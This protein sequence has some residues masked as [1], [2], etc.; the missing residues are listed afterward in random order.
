MICCLS[1]LPRHTLAQPSKQQRALS[2]QSRS[3]TPTLQQLDSLP[4]QAEMGGRGPR[5][6]QVEEEEEKEEEGGEEEGEK[7]EEGEEMM[8]SGDKD[9]LLI[10]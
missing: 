10:C 5:A 3:L 6:G 4:A 8:V 9:C 1:P 2:R 7:E